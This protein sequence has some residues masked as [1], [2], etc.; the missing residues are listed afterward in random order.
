MSF[1]PH[2]LFMNSSRIVFAK[3]I[4]DYVFLVV[5]VYEFLKSIQKEFEINF[6]ATK[7]D[8]SFHILF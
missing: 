4:G 3:N 7:I 2:E 5:T 8:E 6:I 1:F